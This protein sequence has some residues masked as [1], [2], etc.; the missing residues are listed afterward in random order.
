MSNGMKE[1]PSD[2]IEHQFGMALVEAAK[3]LFAHVAQDFSAEQRES[4]RTALAQGSALEIRVQI[5]PTSVV[6][7]VL[8]SVEG[9]THTLFSL[10][11]QA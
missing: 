10:V 9:E 7:C 11:P 6:S 2:E 4:V 8:E 5:R 1:T 3:A